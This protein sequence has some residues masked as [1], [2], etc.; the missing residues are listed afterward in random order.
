MHESETRLDREHHRR[1]AILKTTQFFGSLTDDLLRKIA[2]L[3]ST[4]KLGQGQ[5]LYSEHEEAIALYVVAA[6]EFRSVRQSADGREQVLS[7]ERAG[8]VLAEVAVFNGGKFYRTIVADVAS[9]VLSIEKHQ[10]HQLCREHPE[11]LWNLAKVLGHK[12]RKYADLIESLALRNVEQRLAEYL[13]HVAKERGV[14]AGEGCVVELTLTQTE[15]ANRIGSV[16]EVVSRMFAQLHKAGLIETTGRRLITIPNMQALH[17][18]SGVPVPVKALNLR[19]T[20]L[21]E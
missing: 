5:V 4:H 2:G 17:A 12:I 20:Y 3:V 7:T 11:L 1:V 21:P 6:G 19:P 16:R 8:A 18:F 10:L 14:R 9:E 13:F 15:I